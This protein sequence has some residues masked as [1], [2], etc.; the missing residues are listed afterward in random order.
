MSDLKFGIHLG[1][2]N[3]GLW[4]A[5]A[6]E[7]DRLGY[8]SVWVPEH[9]IVPLASEGSPH[10]GSDH[11]PIPADI[12]IFD[13][14]GVLCYLAA[15]TERIRLGT[16]VYNIG[17]RHPFVTARAASTVDALSGGRL[18]FG[19]GSS[20]LRAEWDA[21]GLDFDR[22]GA[23]VDEAIEICRRLWSEPVIEYHGEFFDFEPVAFEPKLVQPVDAI[24]HVGGD[25]PAAFRRAATI[26]AGWM[27]MNHRLEDLAPSLA[28]ISEIAARAGRTAPL[29]ITM[30]GDL[31]RPED[32]DRYTAAGVT[33]VLIS[34]WQRSSGALDGLRRF[35]EDY[36]PFRPES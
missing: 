2:V 31:N 12:P 30:P 1:R 25:G 26:G 33:R 27:P 29:E 21:V 14:L 7:A 24:F 3:P 11:P 5:V 28:R 18:E 10:H 13:A 23:R 32:I 6:E 19:I 16:N 15:R 36:G 34:P 22:R 17:L 20:W 35:A 9:L 4:G 8:D